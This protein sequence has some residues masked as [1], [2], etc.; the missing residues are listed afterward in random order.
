M[1]DGEV[2]E[3]QANAVHAREVSTVDESDELNYPEGAMTN[4]RGAQILISS[5]RFSCKANVVVLV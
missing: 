1:W 5:D 2:R 4:L 3:E